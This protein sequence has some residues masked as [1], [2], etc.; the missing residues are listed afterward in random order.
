MQ[1]HDKR[2][3]RRRRTSV[4]D[5]RCEYAIARCDDL[6][7]RTLLTRWQDAFAV[8]V[9]SDVAARQVLHVARERAMQ[10]LKSSGNPR[11]TS[12]LR[13]V[14][15]LVHTRMRRRL[16]PASRAD[17]AVLLLPYQR[18]GARGPGDAGASHVGPAQKTCRQL[19]ILPDRKL[20]L[21]G[22]DDTFETIDHMV[23]HTFRGAAVLPRR[24]T[25]SVGAAHAHG[26]AFG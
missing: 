23:R 19:R 2:T 20:R 17:A 9:S 12:L 26:S 14:E 4:C 13:S 8:S 6:C 5:T 18:T 11:P 15:L 16:A 10:E 7:R 25:V 3:N 1:R 21:D 24:I 22:A